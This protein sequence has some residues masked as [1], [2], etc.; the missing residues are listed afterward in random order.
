MSLEESDTV[1]P[2]YSKMGYKQ[3]EFD[4]IKLPFH[5]NKHH[6]FGLGKS[7]EKNWGGDYP[8]IERKVKL[9]IS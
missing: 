2:A 3:H 8:E 1:D 9:F 7:S 4:F 5:F 6:L